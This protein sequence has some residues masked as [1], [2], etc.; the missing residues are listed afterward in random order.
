MPSPIL[1]CKVHAVDII[2]PNKHS[3]AI[4]FNF[5]FLDDVVHKGRFCFPFPPP[6]QLLMRLEH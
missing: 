3:L 6:L 5:P 1:L 2:A 4:L